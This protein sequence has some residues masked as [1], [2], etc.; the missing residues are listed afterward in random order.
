MAGLAAATLLAAEPVWDRFRG[1]NGSG[2]SEG[3]PL[4]A[5]LSP[6]KNAIWRVETPPGYSSPV[7]GA[8]HVLLT[9]HEGGNL[10]TIAIDRKSGKIAWKQ[11][12]PKAIAGKLRGP[13]SPVSPTPATDGRNAYVFF[14]NFGLVSYDRSGKERWRHEL[15]EINNPYGVGASPILA[16]DTLVLLCDQD[17]DSYLLGLDKNTGKQKWKQSRQ[18]VT[19]GF[20]TPIVHKPKN[21]PA[22]VLVSGS[23][24]LTSYSAATGEP[25]WWVNGM[26]WQAKSCPTIA[27]DTLYVHSWMASLSELGQPEKLDPWEKLLAEFDK[28]KDGR[29]APNEANNEQMKS[30]FFLFDL[31]KDKFVDQAEWDMQRQR[32]EARN[33]LYAIRQDRAKGDVT[34]T[35]VR[36]RYDRGLGNLPSPLVYR[37]VVYVLKEGGILTALDPKSGEVI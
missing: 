28:D 8:E 19:H 12:A 32:N 13:N 36:W 18:G 24:R 5:Q 17:T 1:P 2:I 35:H 16:G 30:L 26:A 33:G 4:P 10:F 15:T 23:F 3:A 25:L 34:P 7:I 31:N 9:A 29:I 14:G 21:E 27:G 20:S 11:P 37:D 22:Q 6:S